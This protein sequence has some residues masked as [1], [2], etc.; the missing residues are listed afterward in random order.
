MVWFLAENGLNHMTE[1]GILYFTAYSTNTS[2]RQN[3]RCSCWLAVLPAADSA[4]GPYPLV[5]LC[6][7]ILFV[8]NP[9]D[10]AVSGME[11]YAPDIFV[12]PPDIFVRPLD[13]FDQPLDIFVQ[14]YRQSTR[15]CG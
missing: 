5:C 12:Q 11:G 15:P 8:R 3:R 4:A 9:P 14:G 1:I 13:I 7:L 10:R 6:M 2:G